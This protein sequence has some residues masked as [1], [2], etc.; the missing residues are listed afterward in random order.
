M[1]PLWTPAILVLCIVADPRLQH[2]DACV[3]VLPC[4]YLW[5]ECIRR[6]AGNTQWLR[7]CVLALVLF[8]FLTAKQFEMGEL[9]LLYGSLLLVLAL[10]MRPAS[11][12]SPEIPTPES[13]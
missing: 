12:L 4:V 1:R 10:A 13:A 7:L 3:A 9:V 5:V 8:Q 2:I 11:P 6:L